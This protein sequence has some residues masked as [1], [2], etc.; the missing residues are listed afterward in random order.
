MKKDD[1]E[2]EMK[3]RDPIAFSF[4]DISSKIPLDSY[5]KPQKKSGW[6]WV[7]GGGI[8]LMSAGCA[9]LLC[10]LLIPSPSSSPLPASN[11][12]SN[13]N[14]NEGSLAQ[15]IAIQNPEELVTE[16][17]KNCAFIGDGILLGKTLKNGKKQFVATSDYS[18]D[19]SAFQSGVVGMYPVIVSLRSNPTVQTSYQAEVID[20]TLTGVTLGDYRS[21]YYLGETPRPQDLVLN[22]SCQS[23]ASKEAKVAEYEIDASLYNAKAVG[24][25]SLTAKL[26]SNPAFAV[27][28][29]VEVKALIDADLDGRYA[30]L[31]DTT[32]YGYPT[33]YV[34]ELLK[35]SITSH[36]SEI[37]G[38]GQLTRSLQDDGT[39]LLTNPAGTQSMRYLPS[40][41]TLRVSGIAGDPDM[42][43]FRLNRTDFLITL[44][45]S[46]ADESETRYLALDGR[47]PTSTLDYL[48]YRFGG[49]YRDAAMSQPITHDTIL[50][51]DTTIYV[52]V[53]PRL[54]T[55]TPFYG[56]WYREDSIRYRQ[57][58]F[59]FSEE[60]LFDSYGTKVSSYSVEDKGNGDYWLRLSSGENLVYHSTGDL[61]DILDS[62]TGK[63]YLSL[64]RYN[65][66]VQSLISVETT[67]GVTHRYV[68]DKGTSL[69]TVFQDEISVTFFVFTYGNYHG[70]ALYEDATFP[71]VDVSSAY[72]SDISGIF[73]NLANHVQIV[74]SFTAN[75]FGE[76]HSYYCE[77]TENYALTKSGWVSYGLCQPYQGFYSLIVHYADGSEETL[78]YNLESK[79]LT[80]STFIASSNATPWQDLAC[81]GRY[82][83]TDG[84]VLLALN[85]G[86]LGVYKETSAT[87]NSTEYLTTRITSVASTKVEGYT[88]EE[89][90][91]SSRLVKDVLFELKDTG[92]VLTYGGVT[93]TWK[94]AQ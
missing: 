50:S 16:Y 71:G 94:A 69:T 57:L 74:G 52:G 72:L 85:V 10:L 31:D 15:A 5:T 81:L 83:A 82:Q 61:L 4:S 46:P 18:I 76:G 40:K 58:T 20:D 30:Y 64:K 80:G 70:E 92:W 21:V 51:G 53:K 62:E 34:F 66:S 45:G 29:S 88:I 73:G 42:D 14:V 86:A 93:Y 7:L 84:S 33:F 37:L 55:A 41:R 28:Y 59:A 12:A 56:G 63:S 91:A 23:G 78:S 25:Y 3:D 36:Y 1:L 44:I 19:S 48:S 49:S 89:D 65:S 75:H 38:N 24:T 22:K 9:V 35:D 43:C 17:E 11:S 2:K 47:I 6:G 90:L 60:G 32:E 67:Y 8:G 27:S 68:V 26:K 13:D 54:N 77:F 87:S 79:Q 39:L